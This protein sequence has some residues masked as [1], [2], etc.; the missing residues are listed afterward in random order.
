MSGKIRRHTKVFDNWNV[1]EVIGEGAY[2]VV[3]RLEKSAYGIKDTSVLKVIDLYDN[4]GKRTEL[5]EEHY[6]EMK[7]RVEQEVRKAGR[8]IALMQQLRG[9]TN[10]VDYLDF[11][12]YDWEEEEDESYGTSLLI[13]MEKLENLRMEQRWGRKFTDLEIIRLGKDICNALMLCHSQKILHRDIKPDN[14]YRNENGCYKL[15]D[16]GVSRILDT[17]QN[18]SMRKSVGTRAYMAPEQYKGE[19]YDFRADIYSLGLVMYEL[20][21]GNRLPFAEGIMATGEEVRRRMTEEE[22]PPLS[23]VHEQLTEAIRIACCY[24]PEERYKSA[25][26]FYEELCFTEGIVGMHVALMEASPE[27]FTEFCKCFSIKKQSEIQKEQKEFE[28]ILQAANQGDAKAQYQVGECFLTGKKSVSCDRQEAVKW[29]SLAAENGNDVA[30]CTLGEMYM[31]GLEVEKNQEEALKWLGMSAK[32][33]NAR[34]MFHIGSYH[35]SMAEN[36]GANIVETNALMSEATAWYKLAAEYG[37]SL[38]KI[39]LRRLQI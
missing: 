16:F 8:E 38:G 29:I 18:K 1:E 34:A 20:A 9:S 27:E 21:N 23:G 35:E 14:I 39:A 24:H 3:F 4:F 10:I 22:F 33:K 37:D 30:Q 31:N 11:E 28:A 26:Q 17:V 19:N 2:S 12:V 36:A 13:R 6:N 25:E 15:G 7:E 5:S 32:Q